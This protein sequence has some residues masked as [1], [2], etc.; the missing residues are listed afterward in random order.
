M[1]FSINNRFTT[2]TTV[3]LGALILLFAAF[4]NGFPIVYSDTS[5]YLGSG[6]ELE[7]PFDRPITYG[8]FLRASSF[9]GFSLWFSI[10]FQAL[11]LS[12][13][14]FKLL[15]ICHQKL[16]NTN[17]YFISIITLLSLF[18]S[19]SW[20]TSQLIADIFTPIMILS[21]VIL[22]IDKS[23]KWN[24]TPLYFIFFIATATH[25]SHI[26]F[27][28]LFIFS[29]F[30]IYH[31]KQL[32]VKNVILL[33]PLL[34][35]L[36]L[37]IISILTMGSAISKSKHGFLMGAMVEH[38]IVK[39]FLDENCHSNSYKFC[40]YKDSLPDKAWKFLWEEESPFY[41]MGSWR[42]T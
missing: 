4:I 10:F 17:L 20:T 27:N 6:F 33:K 15:K 41:K 31:L 32:N 8:L 21:L 37:T 18:S 14:I 30:S 1:S 28:V 5:T 39:K 2:L 12:Y 42:E 16:K 29:I 11:I 25:L 26:T 34:V 38:G 7:T 3:L 22:V 9:N 24:K 36:I 23:N 19:V 35:C 13:L 40:A